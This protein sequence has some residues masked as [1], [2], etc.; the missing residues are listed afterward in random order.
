MEKDFVKN[1]MI[2]LAI[3]VIVTLLLAGCSTREV[4]LSKSVT[5]TQKMIDNVKGRLCK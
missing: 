2:L 3:C 4:T 5:V 1:A